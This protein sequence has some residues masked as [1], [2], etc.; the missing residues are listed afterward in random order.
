MSA[1]VLPTDDEFE[2][3]TIVLPI[4]S[5]RSFA[6]QP[7]K[8]FDEAKH[9]QLTAS[10]AARRRVIEPLVARPLGPGQY[11][12]ICGERR[13]RAAKAAGLASVP[14]VVRKMSDEEAF[15]ESLA[16]NLDREDLA[17]IDEVRAVARLVSLYGVQETGRRLGKPHHWVSKRK[18]IGEAAGFVVEFLERGASNDIE[19][20]YELAKLA[21]NDA[22]AAQQII[23]NH[24]EAGHLRQEVKAAARAARG[25]N[26]DDG[27][28]E[29]GGSRRERGDVLESPP[30]EEGFR[31]DN[32]SA[33]AERGDDEQ[34]DDEDSEASATEG[35][36][37]PSWLPSGAP[38]L[39]DPFDADPAVLVTSVEARRAGHLV[40]T[41]ANG[42][43]VYE[44]TAQARAELQA[45]LGPS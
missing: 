33:A 7:R 38:E 20:I 22:D 41:T 18:R 15:E 6:D 39:D 13:W 35:D 44:L 8:T 10:V 16:E 1:A 43:V 11:E 37:K 27:G 14:V 19:A 5:L 31:L 17:P 34:D 36:E 3:P 32:R 45:L 28:D 40:F 29:E 4:D 25:E 24:T 21:E 9:D 12:I 26:D 42:E 30:T 23:S 2:A